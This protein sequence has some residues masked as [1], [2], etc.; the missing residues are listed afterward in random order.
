[1]ATIKQKLAF[2][3]VVLNGSTLTKAM[4]K[5]G[6]ADTTATTTGK[7]TNTKGWRELMQ[8]FI[9]DEELV[10]KHKEQLNSSKLVKLYFDIDDEDEVIEDVCKKLGVELLYVKVNKTKD[11]KTANVKAPDFFF[12]DL[13]LDKGYKVKG[14]YSTEEGGN[15]T[16]IINITGETASRYGILPNATNESTS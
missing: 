9:P 11:G 7:L 6:Y 8:Q 14:R 15:K 4:K 13:A 5:A 3:E 1:M 12:R 10:Q 2:R 16:L